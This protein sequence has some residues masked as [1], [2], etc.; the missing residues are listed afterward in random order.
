MTST[1]LNSDM[2]KNTKKNPNIASRVKKKVGN[3]IKNFVDLFKLP[4]DEKIWDSFSEKTK[5]EML[6]SLKWMNDFDLYSIDLSDVWEADVTMEWDIV[7]FKKWV[8]KKDEI[9]NYIMIN[10]MKCRE[11]Q[12]WITWFAYKNI[13]D[14]YHFGE[15]LRIWFCEKWIFKKSVVIDEAFGPKRLNIMPLK[16]SEELWWPFYEVD[17]INSIEKWPLYDIDRHDIFYRKNNEYEE[18][19][20]DINSVGIKNKMVHKNS[21]KVSLIVKWKVFKEYENW[22]SGF[23][24]KEFWD[25]YG[26][27]SN[28]LL[29]AEYKDW[30][31]VW[32]WIIV[33]PTEKMYIIARNK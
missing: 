16:V 20:F 13:R 21:W 29:L 30:K 27:R 23:V 18:T 17:D 1:E 11:Y 28:Y 15:W 31:M 19:S 5:K 9:W 4:N 10:D 33:T 32:E 14:K 24:Y 6:E 7:K 26:E 2:S 22:A 25:P 8:I 3:H 12:P